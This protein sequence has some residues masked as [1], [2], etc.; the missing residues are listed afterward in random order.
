M[1]DFKLLTLSDA[2]PAPAGSDVTAVVAG[3][4]VAVVAGD[5]AIRDTTARVLVIPLLAAG[6]RRVA[7]SL[8]A[9]ANY[10]HTVTVAILGAFDPLGAV[11]AQLLSATYPASAGYDCTIGAGAP[12]Q[13]GTA[14][15][16]TVADGAHYAVPALADAFPYLIVKLTASGNATTGKFRLGIARS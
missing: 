2:A 12:G 14:G 3:A 5:L 11:T 10:S 9:Y 6:Y 1:P 13:G 15:G 16:A 8:L 4:N 7:L